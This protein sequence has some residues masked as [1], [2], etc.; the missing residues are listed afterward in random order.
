MVGYADVMLV[1]Q[2]GSGTAAMESGREDVGILPIGSEIITILATCSGGTGAPVLRHGCRVDQT[3]L[4][5]T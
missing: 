5:R 2:T 4:D 3:Y 1:D